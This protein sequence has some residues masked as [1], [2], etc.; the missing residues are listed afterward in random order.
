MYICLTPNIDT[1]YTCPSEHRPAD[2]RYVEH[3]QCPSD[4]I[5]RVYPCIPLRGSISSSGYLIPSS[6]I[7]AAT[8]ARSDYKVTLSYLFYARVDIVVDIRLR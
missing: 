2:S 7:A 6:Y 1:N 4:I 3:G 8:I 5:P